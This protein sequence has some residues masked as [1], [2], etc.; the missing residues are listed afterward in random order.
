MATYSEQLTS[1]QAAI[2]RIEE[3]GQSYTIST[4]TGSRTVT[5]ADLETLYTRE[6]ELRRLVDRETRGG[7]RSRGATPI[8]NG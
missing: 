8:S 1:V 6:K 7:I 4:A 2:E 5:R 3:G